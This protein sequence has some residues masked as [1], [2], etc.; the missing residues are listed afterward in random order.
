MPV[1][2]GRNTYEVCAIGHVT[3]DVVV[4]TD[5]SRRQ[6]LGGAA[7]YAAAALGRLGVRT[8]VITK[9]AARDGKHASTALRRLGIRPSLLPSGETTIFENRYLG[10]E[11]MRQQRVRAIA[12]PFAPEDLGG[13]QAEIIH[14]GPLTPAEMPLEFLEAA[15]NRAGRIV[16]DV[17]GYL[18]RIEDGQVRQSD[19]P[20]KHTGLRYA[21]VVKANLAEARV[22]TGEESP[23]H[24]ARRLSEMGPREALVTL[25]GR[26]ALVFAHGRLH[27]IAP[28]PA[29]RIQDPTGCGDSF[30]AGYLYRRFRGDDPNTAARFAA[31]VATLKLETSGPFQGS[32]ADVAAALARG[33]LV[34]KR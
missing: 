26:G 14:L 11:G 29:R 17:Q 5:G 10:S 4:R 2:A 33:E 34:A 15:A 13:A 7:Y 32:D 12:A 27:C 22:L 30:C 1:M 6:M 9:M 24:A 23:E 31:A 25:G 8:A 3:R 18:R 20:Q 16:L 19:W 28:I 21:H